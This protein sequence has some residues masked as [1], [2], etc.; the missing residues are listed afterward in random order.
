MLF[1]PEYE[2]RIASQR[3]AIESAEIRAIRAGQSFTGRPIQRALDRALL[4]ISRGA[5]RREA[6]RDA[7]AP[8]GTFATR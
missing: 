4:R 6:E 2:T 7:I 8:P 1:D 5:S 3:L